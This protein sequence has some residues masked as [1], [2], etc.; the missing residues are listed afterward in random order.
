ME[1]I[2]DF[3][4][5]DDTLEELGNGWV[6]DTVVV[7]GAAVMVNGGKPEWITDK[8]RIIDLANQ[9]T[10]IVAHNLQCDVGILYNWGVDLSDKLLVDTVVLAKLF[11]NTLPRYSLDYLGLLFYGKRK[12]TNLLGLAVLDHDLYPTALDRT[13][14]ANITKANNFAYKNMDKVYAVAPQAVIDYA[15]TDII[16][17]HMLYEGLN[18]AWMRPQVERIS[19]LFK[20]LLKNRKKGI[21]IS[22]DNLTNA[23][24]TFLKKEKALLEAIRTDVQDENFDPDKPNHLKAVYQDRGFELPTTAKGSP[25]LTSQWLDKQEDDLSKSIREYRKYQKARRDYCDKVLE[26]QALMP[27]KYRG[28]VYPSY[29]VFGARTGRFSSQD[30]NIQQIPGR[31]EEIGGLVRSIYVPEDGHKWFSLDFS[32]QEFR[33]F[34]H[35]V[36][37]YTGL[38]RLADMF[39]AD[40]RTDFYSMVAG[41]MQLK[42]PNARDTAKPIALGRLYGLGREKL[43][44]AMG[45]SIPQARKLLA[46]YDSKFPEAKQLGRYLDTQIEHQGYITTLGGRKLRTGEPDFYAQSYGDLRDTSKDYKYRATNYTIQGTAAD[47]IIDTWLALDEAGIDVLCSVHDEMNFSLPDDGTVSAAQ[48]IMQQAF[49]LM[50]PMVSDIGKGDS[51]ADAKIDAKAQDRKRK[52]KARGL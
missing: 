33:I 15:L 14:P 27:E 41:W 46:L 21:R 19:K 29:T 22:I 36:Y 28:R 31:D 3:E 5:R 17:T 39:V 6:F 32:Q 16:L 25:S 7:V 18:K 52:L 47:Q 45:I 10:I 42:G 37:G 20:V 30:P 35:I 40:P 2:I 23:R 50:V 44:K 38:K 8:Q 43:A 13:K 12:D 11:N 34:A 51:W 48:R 4:F 49:P 26:N 9:A 24:D 1:L